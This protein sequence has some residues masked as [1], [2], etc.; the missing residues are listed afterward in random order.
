MKRICF[1][2]IGLLALAGR[3]SAQSEPSTQASAPLEGAEQRRLA[4]LTTQDSDGA[5]QQAFDID[6]LEGDQ[7]SLYLS[8]YHL[9]RIAGDNQLSREQR[10]DLLQR[11]SF[12]LEKGLSQLTDP[13]VLMQVGT[14]LASQGVDEQTSVLEY[15]GAS[16]EGKGM[17]RPIAETAVAVFAQATREATSQATDL[18]NQITKPDDP[19][20]ED[21]RKMNDLAGAAAYQT[22]RMQYSFAL[23]LD[24]VDPRRERLIEEALGAFSQWDSADSG[25]QPQVRLLM[26]KLH[27]LHG[28]QEEFDKGRDLIQ[29]L[30]ATDDSKPS[31]PPSA[32]LQFEARCELVLVALD[33]QDVGAAQAALADATADQQANFASDTEQ[34]ATLRLLNYRLLALKADQTPEGDGKQAAQAASTSALAQ[35]ASDFPGLRSVIYQQL[36][37]RVAADADPAKLPTLVLLALVDEGKQLVIAAGERG[38]EE[39]ADAKET[40]TLQ[41]SLGAAREL[42]TR[43]SAGKIPADQAADASLMVG[44]FTEFLGDKFAA[45]DELLDHV[46]RFGPNTP[47]EVAAIAKTDFALDRA[48]GLI[49]D[50]RQSL[51]VDPR[52]RLDPR[53]ERLQDRFLPIA[54]NPPFNRREFAFQYAASLLGQGK[55]KAAAGY[56]RIVPD[57]DTPDHV[58]AARYGEMVALKNDLDEES[59]LT[60]S[61]RRR[62]ADEIEKLAETVRQSAMTIADSDASDSDKVRAKSTLARTALLAADVTR[63]E[64]HDPQKVLDLLEGFEDRVSGLPDA[65]Q[66][67]NGALFLRVQ[68]YMELGRNH[69]ATMTLVQYLNATGGGEG[70]QTVHDLLTALNRDL[71]KARADADADAASG[72]AGG[73]RAAERTI[74]QLAANRAMLSGY[75]VQW[76][77]DST[78]PSIHAHA[79]TYRRFDADSK[80]LAA[81]LQA[82]PQARKQELQEVLKLYQDLQSPENVT[83][84]Q[85]SLDPSADAD[86]DYPDP[87]VTLGI[88]LTAYDLGDCQTVKQTL[89]QLIHDQKLGEDNDQYWEATFKLLD[90]MYALARSGDAGT[91]MLQVQQSL[92][93]LYLI[94]R[95]GT[96]GPKWHAKFEALRKEV[97]PDWTPP[98]SAPGSGT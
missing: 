4:D 20:A 54:I 59:G 50:L 14:L 5:L 69:D 68:S 82:D 87:L 98:I 91:P 3:A 79:Y 49:A 93:V 21:W 88:G 56:Y 53:V 58:L 12:D 75:L 30:L 60:D 97:L 86:K 16:D 29:S 32:A 70:A 6:G 35:L 71:D 9:H 64:K 76:A 52:G 57:S 62:R 55:W 84:Y 26:G 61:Q 8:L 66:L 46:Q 18:A 25:I 45:V 1:L 2:M 72:D 44:I 38:S 67:L 80:R 27:V 96:G 40:A 83:L 10:L 90:C 33:S 81:E 73:Q 39:P 17:L 41:M 94:W 36:S 37:A 24:A 19:V 51:P 15:W 43:Y 77:S 48:R 22:A 65:A 31:P 13:N 63:R 78:D 47:A 89:G 23:S 74:Q 34:A 95:D 11:A 28:T 85:A 92:K 42:V 7:R